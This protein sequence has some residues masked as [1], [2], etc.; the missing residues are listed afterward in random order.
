MKPPAVYW[1]TLSGPTLA[2]SRWPTSGINPAPTLATACAA[3]PP[4][5]AVLAWGGPSL[6]T[7]WKKALINLGHHDVLRNGLTHI[8]LMA[9]PLGQHNFGVFGFLVRHLLQQVVNAVEPG[10][11][12]V[13]RL[14]HPPRRLGNVR[15]L[16]HDFLGLGV[17]L[18]AA[19]GLQV[20]GAELP[21]LERVVD[22]AQK[23]QVL[24]LVRNRK[25]VFDELYARAHQHFFKLRHGAE[26]LLVLLIGAEAHDTLDTGAVVPAA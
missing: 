11:F 8:V 13:V 9:H 22:A 4:E 20:H 1:P 16:Q 7:T 25:P 14:H 24:L 10:F 23:A 6:R 26:E 5:G 3:L 2:R 19:P 21:L 18:P 12:L 15:A 17:L